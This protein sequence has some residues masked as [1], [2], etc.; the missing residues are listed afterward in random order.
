[1]AC[2]AT[3]S[4]L[5]LVFSLTSPVIGQVCCEPVGH[6]GYGA[7]WATAW[8][9]ELALVGSGPKLLV[10]DFRLGA[11]QPIL[12]EVGLPGSILAIDVE[13]DYAYVGLQTA[14]TAAEDLVVIVDLSDPTQP[15]M[16]GRIGVAKAFGD[17]AVQDHVIHATSILEGFFTVDVSDPWNPKLLAEIS[18]IWN[19]VAIE[20]RGDFAYLGAGSNLAVIYVADPA[21]PIL[22]QENWLREYARDLAVSGG[23]LYHLSDDQL[24]VFDLT[25]PWQ[26]TPR[27]DFETPG[28]SLGLGVDGDTVYLTDRMSADMMIVV[29]AADPD[30][31]EQIGNYPTVHPAWD[32]AADEG[33]VLLSMD[34]LGA[35]L[36]DVTDPSAPQL[37]AELPPPAAPGNIVDAGIDRGFAHLADAGATSGPVPPVGRFRVIDVSQGPPFR[38]VGALEFEYPGARVAIAGDHVLFTR[39]DDVGKPLELDV[40]DVSQPASPTVVGSVVLGGLPGGEI[41]VVGHH[42]YIT[43][44]RLNIVDLSDPTDPMIT[45]TTYGFGGYRYGVS[46]E[47][48]RAYL[49]ADGNGLC[50]VDVSDPANPVGLSSTP[51]GTSTLWLAERDGLAFM[52]AE[53]QEPK[54][55][56]EDELRIYDRQRRFRTGGDC[57]GGAVGRCRSSQ[58]RRRSRLCAGDRS[59]SADLRHFGSCS[60]GSRRDFT[61]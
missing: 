22:V 8:H 44:A 29:D 15:V 30:S 35:Q 34:T 51:I 2:R 36:V 58:R 53:P 60:A 39:G 14:V 6:W 40:I 21:A 42:A 41:A 55:E 10:A 23:F 49:A 28:R 61:R 38:E 33:A 54:P 47:G 32:V 50:V 13:G 25:I 27:G 16:T 4:L 7:T 24:S 43:D 20:V 18:G 9:G 57:L 1:M 26:P 46:V 12:G 5:C 3:V 59:W 19:A 48:D 31:L 56:W 45:S 52:T 11:P 17:L 37:F